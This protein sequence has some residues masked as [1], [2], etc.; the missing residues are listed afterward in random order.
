MA[1]WKKIGDNTN[2]AGTRTITYQPENIPQLV[3]QSR[4][5]QIPHVNGVD[6]WP[7]RQFFVLLN[8]IEQK[9]CNSLKDAKAFCEELYGL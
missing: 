7:I 4:T 9:R 2:S 1:N 5:Y 3:V 8:G 6:T